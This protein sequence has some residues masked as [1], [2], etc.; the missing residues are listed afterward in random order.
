MGIDWMRNEEL[1]QAIPPAYSEYLAAQVLRALDT[2]Y[3]H[4]TRDFRG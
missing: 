3:A 2:G 4:L 1:S